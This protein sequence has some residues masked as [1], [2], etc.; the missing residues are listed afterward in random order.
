MRE[1][2]QSSG[3][4]PRSRP[5]RSRVGS[6]RAGEGKA[7]RLFLAVDV[8]K[9]VKESLARTI[10]PLV[11]R[12]PPARW[13]NQEGWHVTLKFLGATWPRLLSQ[14]QQAARAAAGA[15][16]A[17]QTSL[18][19]VGS[20]PTSS[21]ARVL[22]AGLTDP[23]GRFDRLVKALDRELADHFVAEKRAFTPHLTLA[24]INP[25]VDLRKVAPELVG[26]PLHARPFAVERLVLY[27]SHLSPRGARYEALH[28]FE[29]G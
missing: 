24:R 10:A 22:W 6:D 7:L 5:G 9:D 23:E 26:M 14:V 18:A 16:E 12:L 1:R 28:E 11:D 29:L 4:A 15:S 27:Q 19:E 17:F 21:R 13:T 8:P 3:P 20:F 2:R 25:P